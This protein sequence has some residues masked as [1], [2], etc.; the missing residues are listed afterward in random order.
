MS[1]GRRHASLPTINIETE[2]AAPQPLKSKLALPGVAQPGRSRSK[3]SIQTQTKP[4]AELFAMDEQRSIQA[5]AALEKLAAVT[6][7]GD[8]G[9][10]TLETCRTSDYFRELKNKIEKKEKLVLS[11]YL[12]YALTTDDVNTVS[13]ELLEAATKRKDYHG[14]KNN[15]QV[16]LTARKWQEAKDPDEKNALNIKL[17]KDLMQR[18]YHHREGYPRCEYYLNLHGI[19]LEGADLNFVS[20]D[21]TDLGNANLSGCNLGYAHIMYANL[22]QAN[23]SNAHAHSPGQSFSES[24][25]KIEYTIAMNANFNGFKADNISLKNSDFTGSNMTN[26]EIAIGISF[27]NDATITFDFVDFSGSYVHFVKQ[28]KIEKH[29]FVN[30]C[31]ANLTDCKIGNADYS[32]INCAGAL[33]LP[34]TAFTDPEQFKLALEAAILRF[35]QQVSLDNI[36]QLEKDARLLCMKQRIADVLIQQLGELSTLSTRDKIELINIALLPQLLGRSA[37]LL[38]VQVGSFFNSVSTTL[39]GPAKT[40]D[41]SSAAILENELSKL[42]KPALATGIAHTKL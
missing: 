37:G 18:G 28:H 19:N 27:E 23:F 33:M 20:L 11:E 10:E 36:S 1:T 5:Y 6:G 30:M 3:W 29:T 13:I 34:L 12:Y 15:L 14:F 32:R 24:F 42:S 26:A 39:F 4:E 31:F 8:K 21:F 2:Q 38:P 22:N 41:N 40:E 17:R 7:V 25:T 9:F 35:S 16:L